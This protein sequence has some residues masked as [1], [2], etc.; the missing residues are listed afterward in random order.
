MKNMTVFDFWRGQEERGGH[1]AGAEGSAGGEGEAYHCPQAGEVRDDQ[2][3][4]KL[5]R[6]R[7]GGEAPGGQREAGQEGAHHVGGADDCLPDE[8][9]VGPR[10]L[11]DKTTLPV[12]GLNVPQKSKLYKP[13]FKLSAVKFERA[14]GRS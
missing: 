6:W 10:I 4:V 12:Q 5:L 7:G 2:V 3:C 1:V 11:P 13:N 14:N 9:V 8:E